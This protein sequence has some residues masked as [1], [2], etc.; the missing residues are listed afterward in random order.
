MTP[1]DPELPARWKPA[2][3]FMREYR[4]IFHELAK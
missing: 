4:N 2:R 1:F 3:E